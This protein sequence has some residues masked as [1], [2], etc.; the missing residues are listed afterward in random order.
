MRLIVFGANGA[1][2]RR[3]L[4]ECLERG[5]EVS[6]AVR[7]VSRFEG[8][9][10]EITVVT[11]DATDAP[12]IAAAAAGHDAALSAVTQHLHPEILSEVASAL[13]T[14]LAEAGVPRLVVAGGA[15]SLEVADGT[16]LMDT[17][18]FHD[19]WK[20]EARA[21]ADALDVLRA[22]DTDVEWSYVSPGALLEPGERTGEYRKGGDR[23]L[24]DDEGRSRITMEDFAIAMVDE[25]VEPKHSRTRFTVA[26]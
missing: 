6:A 26:H 10:R 1:L 14:G 7:D 5:I 24:V 25:A 17:P 12:S 18:D 21:Q 2:G 16:R 19:D 23:L 15:G 13:L 4:M 8:A 11:A 22:A 3:L 9:A 20:P